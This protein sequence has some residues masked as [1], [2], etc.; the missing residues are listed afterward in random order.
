MKD[1]RKT[2][3]SLIL[4]QLQ[5]SWVIPESVIKK[6]LSDQNEE[7]TM[8][9]ECKYIRTQIEGKENIS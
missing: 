1:G 3:P 5:T 9:I 7:E 4:S 8:F 2:S 6:C